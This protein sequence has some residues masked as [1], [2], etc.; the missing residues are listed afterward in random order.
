MK[1]EMGKNGTW[2]FI[3]DGGGRIVPKDRVGRRI[4][5]NKDA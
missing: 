1:W 3:G 4:N 2:D 5:D